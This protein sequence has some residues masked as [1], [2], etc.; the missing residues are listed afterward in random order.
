MPTRQEVKHA[1]IA[2]AVIGAVAFVG[3]LLVRNAGE[4]A[5]QLVGLAALVAGFGTYALLSVRRERQERREGKEP[6]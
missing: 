5:M 6:Q 3:A 4:G 2:I 1:N